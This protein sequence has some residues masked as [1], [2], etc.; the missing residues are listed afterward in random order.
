MITIRI[1]KT[2]NTKA[3]VAGDLRDIA[4]AIEDGD[5]VGDDWEIDGRE[6]VESFNTG[7]E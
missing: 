7:A 4:K 6:E 2:K 3:D 5:T 1:D